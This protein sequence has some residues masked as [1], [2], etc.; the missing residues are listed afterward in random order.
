MLVAK[1]QAKVQQG[2]LLQEIIATFWL[3]FKLSK[4]KLQNG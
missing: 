1:F 4:N 3:G 2:F